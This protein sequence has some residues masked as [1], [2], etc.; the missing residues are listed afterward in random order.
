[1]F[2]TRCGAANVD[3]ARFCSNCGSALPAGASQAEATSAR[4]ADETPHAPPAA[5]PESVAVQPRYAGFWIRFAALFIDG[6]ITGA[7]A[8]AVGVV[9]GALA[10]V[11]NRDFAAGAAVGYY[12]S[13]LVIRWLYFALSESSVRG[14]TLGKRAV[15]IFVTDTAGRRISFGR[16]T[17]RTF[18]K[19]L[20]AMTLGVGWL[21]AAFT[22][23]KQGLHDLVAGTLVVARQDA[24]RMNPG[25]F[26]VLLLAMS[27]PVMGIIA[28]IAIPGLLRARMAG[29]EA[30][31]IGSLRTIQTAQQNYSAFCGGYAPDLAELTRRGSVAFED[32]TGSS[33][34]RSGYTITMETPQGA[35]A[36]AN[37][38]AG[39]I[40]TVSD[41]LAQAVPVTPGSTGLRYFATDG[42][43]AILQDSNATFANATPL[44]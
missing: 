31:A 38:P 24:R 40:G 15:G 18:A 44:P 19:L 7:G 30:S 2:C 41:Y 34:R 5:A 13:Y 8:I 26:A 11:G 42:G 14:A 16:A 17:G 29:N 28:A 32:V 3:A 39:C 43:G 12:L 1:M 4:V 9:I 6:L 21:L 27:I 20:N 37:P 35:V 36:V 25:V 22:D 33:F 10:A 23:R